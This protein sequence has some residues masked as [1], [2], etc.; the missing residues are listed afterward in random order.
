MRTEHVDSEGRTV[1]RED[2]DTRETVLSDKDLRDAYD[3]GRSDEAVRHKRNWLLTIVT[4]L[5]ALIGLIVL[6]L[7]A[8]NG[9]F[10]RG[11]AVI[12]QQLSLAADQAE[13]AV[14][15][16][17]S[18]A[19]EEIREARTDE[20]APDTTVVQTPSGPVPATNTA[21]TTPGAY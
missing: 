4:A 6:V 3:R 1:V 12:D 17:A 2:G 18:E 10:A 14:R 13:P 8:L 15:N 19:A 9:S 7:A 21:T 5:L 11:G 16:A 20:P